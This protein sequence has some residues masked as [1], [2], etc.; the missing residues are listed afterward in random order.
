MFL[1]NIGVGD[2]NEVSNAMQMPLALRIAAVTPQ[3]V[4]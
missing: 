1:K 3:A 2:R 4:H